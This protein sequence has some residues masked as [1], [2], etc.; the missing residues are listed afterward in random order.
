MP[1]KQ[2]RCRLEFRGAPDDQ[3]ERLARQVVR[4]GSQRRFREIPIGAPGHRGVERRRV[5]EL[6]SGESVTSRLEQYQAG[7]ETKV[8]I[9]GVRAPVMQDVRPPTIASRLRCQ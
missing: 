2:G 9:V 3:A 1:R 6:S 4:P 8:G 7:P 5:T